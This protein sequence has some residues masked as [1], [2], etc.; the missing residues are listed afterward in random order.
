MN[1]VLTKLQLPKLTSVA[2]DLKVCARSR[3]RSAD[4]ALSRAHRAE[5]ALLL[6]WRVIADLARDHACVRCITTQS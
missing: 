5:P 1:A 4:R 6:S 3:P 2:F